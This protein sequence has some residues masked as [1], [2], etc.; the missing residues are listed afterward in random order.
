MSLG[1][2]IAPQIAGWVFGLVMGATLGSIRVGEI[3]SSAGNPCAVVAMDKN[4]ACTCPGE[5]FISV[6]MSKGSVSRLFALIVDFVLDVELHG[7]TQR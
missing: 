3:P 6:K 5:T 7:V 4:W 2:S 1:I